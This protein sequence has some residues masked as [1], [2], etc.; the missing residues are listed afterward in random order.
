MIEA[1]MQAFRP[2][3]G[4]Y[5][6]HLP[7]PRMQFAQAPMAASS[8]QVLARGAAP[9]PAPVLVSPLEEPTTENVEEWRDAVKHARAAVEDSNNTVENLTMAVKYGAPVWLEH[10]ATTQVLA[11]TLEAC[12][13]GMERTLQA[14][15]AARRAEQEKGAEAL[16]NVKRRRLATMHRVG[17][18]V[19]KSA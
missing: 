7:Y 18:L 1:E 6:D 8:S 5:I 10:N 13:E 9:E 17:A 4:N 19:G 12:A 3:A 16:Y 11:R 2:P 15:N 14:G